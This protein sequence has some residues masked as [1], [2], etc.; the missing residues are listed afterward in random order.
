MT[1]SRDARGVRGCFRSGAR[2]A[3]GR[4]R[5]LFDGT[6]FGPRVLG[7]F[8]L[9]GLLGACSTEPIFL[10]PHPDFVWWT[11]H[12]TGDLADW[13]QGGAARASRY[14]AGAGSAEVAPIVA[15][16][17]RHGLVSR[18]DGSGAGQLTR[19]GDVTDGAYYGAWFYVP[20]FARP[21]S[22]WVFFALRAQ[23]ESPLWDLKLSPVGDEMRLQLLH[24]DT[25]DVAPVAVMPVPIG[26]WFQVQAFFAASAS[27]NDRLLVWLDGRLVYE[28]A[29]AAVEGVANPTP[30]PTWT[31]GTITDGLSPAPA[32]LYIDDAFIA[33]RAISADTPAFWRAP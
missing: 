15:R 23:P 7:V 12:E 16:S 20:A 21:A 13:L 28:V 18:I 6:S 29:G 25:G 8:L 2:W 3:T 5:A 10:G 27:A 31:L 24:H 33:R 9:L 11:D 32:A 14:T 30:T 17:G 22:Y 1:K 26:R 19:R 4:G